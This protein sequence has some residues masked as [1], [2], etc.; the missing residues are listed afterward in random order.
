MVSS[1]SH[2]TV[3]VGR[4]WYKICQ[5]KMSIRPEGEGESSAYQRV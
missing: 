3:D 2:S 1:S 4:W 5:A